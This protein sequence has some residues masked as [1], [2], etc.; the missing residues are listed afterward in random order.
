MLKRVL[1]YVVVMLILLALAVSAGQW[2]KSTALLQQYAIEIS[3]WLT[4]HESSG[5]SSSSSSTTPDSQS[6]GG[7]SSSS[8]APSSSIGATLCCRGRTQM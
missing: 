8:T 7:G 3:D 1:L 5:R 6:E 4:E 2:D